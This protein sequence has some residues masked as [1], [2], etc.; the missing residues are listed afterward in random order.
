MNEKKHDQPKE[1]DE[2][3]KKEFIRDVKEA[4]W[5]G[6]LGI[7]LAVCI[8]I[9]LIFGRYLDKWFGTEPIFTI[10]FIG[11]GVAAGARS[12]YRAVKKYL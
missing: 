5:L 12:I 1:V 7:N 2:Q 4:L 3:E 10:L 11:F 6:A 9:G 8:V